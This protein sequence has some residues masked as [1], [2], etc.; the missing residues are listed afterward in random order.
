MALK[1]VILSILSD[2][3]CTGYDISNKFND[4][5]GNFWKSTHQQIYRE[6]AKMTKSGHVTFDELQQQDK[7]N[8]KI[9]KLTALGSDELQVWLFSTDDLSPKNDT[10]LVKL[11]AAR[12]SGKDNL[13]VIIKKIQQT[14]QK[15]LQEYLDI[16][17][18]YFSKKRQLNNIDKLV[19]MTL[20]KG[21]LLEQ[22]TIAWCEECYQSTLTM[23]AS[24]KL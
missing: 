18:Q 19:Y 16:E 22:S 9:Y 3:S 6:L 8:K 2:E 15:K 14:H 7:P 24:I 13:G 20:R 21:I 1:H 4:I 17:H 12:H 5:L 23:E 11:Y 10:E